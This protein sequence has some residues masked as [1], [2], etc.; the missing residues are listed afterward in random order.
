MKGPSLP[1][2]SYFSPEC[3]LCLASR[4]EGSTDRQVNYGKKTWNGLQLSEGEHA[5]AGVKY[6]GDG[7]AA[8]AAA[9]AAI[10]D[11]ERVRQ[12]KLAKKAAFDA[13]YD[14]GTFLLFAASSSSAAERCT[15]LWSPAHCTAETFKYMFLL[16]AYSG[17]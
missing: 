7:D 1:C 3:C 11:E 16:G 13:E 15:Q 2:K 17:A 5:C 6:S 10:R 4:R 14:A 12:A 8:T 9:M